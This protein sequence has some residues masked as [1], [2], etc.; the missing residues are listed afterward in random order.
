MHAF[1]ALSGGKFQTAILPALRRVRPA[2]LWSQRY[3]RT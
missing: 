3:A 1:A 2:D